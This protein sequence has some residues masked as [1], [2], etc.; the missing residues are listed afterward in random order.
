MIKV[1]D[2]AIE[3]SIKIG[4]PRIDNGD[5]TLFFT[6]DRTRY[7]SRGYSKLVRTL[8]MA[9]RD[10]KP[11]FVLPLV[12]FFLNC[13][14]KEPPKGGGNQAYMT[15]PYSFA[16]PFIDLKEV[17]VSTKDGDKTVYKLASYR[18]PE[19]YN[20]IKFGLDT[21]NK[22]DDDNIFWT[23]MNGKLYLLPD[24]G[25]YT[26]INAMGIE[27]TTELT[28]DDELNIDRS[29]ADMLITFAAI[30]AMT[31][32]PNPQKV[33]LYRG[34]LIDDVSVLANYTNLREHNEGNKGN[35]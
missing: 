29:Y 8:S 11:G 30:E 14:L 21:I 18:N 26:T 24:E 23:V 27:D 1:K 19:N 34:M 22:A 4:D 2:L 5:G 9:M 13:R 12:P 7:I 3:L 25:K 17:V 10:Y 33:N 32:L 28:T 35:G 16:K 20:Q 6:T 15:N 31:D